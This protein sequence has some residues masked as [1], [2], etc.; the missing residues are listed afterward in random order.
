MT[1]RVLEFAGTPSE[2]GEAF[3]ESCRAEIAEL[4]ALRLENAL[5]QAREYGG[6]NPREAD[7]LALAKLCR[8]ATQAHHPDGFAEL[9][10]IAAGARQSVERVL[11]LG[12]LTDLRDTLAWGGTLEAAGGCTGFVVQGDAS[13]SGRVLCGQ[14][15]DLT[16]DNAPFVVA[17][18][19]K[20]SDGPETRCVTTVGCLSLMGMNEH[21][22]AVG[23]TN[24]R[25]RDA[26]VGVPYLNLIHRALASRA[27]ADAVSSLA[28]ARRAAAHS[29]TIVGAE[30]QAVVLE[31]SAAHAHPIRV[32][33]GTHVHCNHCLLP[34]HA[35]SEGDTPRRSS[36][37][38]Y[39]RMS[40]LLA[41]TETHDLDS[42]QRLLADTKN[43][44]L[45]ICRD[46]F[47]G[48]S[49]NAAIVMD[50][51]ERKIRACQGLPSRAEW[52]ELGF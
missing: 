7:L 23:T 48:I 52:V 27:Y 29:Y 5:A 41:E 3:G 40:E 49:T 32:E 12:G 45:A 13:V 9:C 18:H 10:G 25:T 11:A 1:L 17:V 20:P 47:S 46:D 39:T 42:L 31:C 37:A 16:T 21:G 33:R 44:E 4:Y 34:E 30:G 8:P 36:E 28:S 51:A 19:R 24:L 26:R 15:W 6:R 38:R 2:M 35:A 22:I 43:G 50:P 14:S